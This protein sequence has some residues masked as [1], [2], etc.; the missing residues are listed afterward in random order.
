MNAITVLAYF[1]ITA[2]T[3]VSFYYIHKPVRQ[4]RAFVKLY[5]RLNWR[6]EQ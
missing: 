4:A 3:A 2:A 6:N 1:A 5:N